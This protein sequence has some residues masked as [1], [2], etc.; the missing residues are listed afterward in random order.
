MRV[1]E[2]HEEKASPFGLG[3]RGAG[4]P[5]S[6][7]LRLA[8][9]MQEYPAPGTHASTPILRSRLGLHESFRPLEQ[10][11]GA[12]LIGAPTAEFEAPQAVGGMQGRRNACGAW[13]ALVLPAQPPHD[14]CKLSSG[15]RGPA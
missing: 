4:N 2:V 1:R 14:F 8:R 12:D 6:H 3:A 11:A 13:N 15:N 9:G 10:P 7:G 5:G